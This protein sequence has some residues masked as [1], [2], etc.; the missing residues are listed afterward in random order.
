MTLSFQSAPELT[1]HCHPTHLI[2]SVSPRTVFTRSPIASFSTGTGP[3]GVSMSVPLRRQLLPE[4]PPCSH[5]FV[6]KARAGS[7]DRDE[8]NAPSAAAF[9]AIPAAAPRK[10]RRARLRGECEL[11]SA[12][13]YPSALRVPGIGLKSAW[14]LAKHDAPNQK[15]EA[16]IRVAQIVCFSC[17]APRLRI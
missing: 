13:M 2:G 14:I 9:A 12:D 10:C 11:L 15:F 16:S 17:F 4:P 5:H 1:R 7:D 8:A 3:F 6:P